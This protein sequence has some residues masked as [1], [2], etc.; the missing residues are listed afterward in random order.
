[1]LYSF[2]SFFVVGIGMGF[3]AL[4]TLLVVQAGLDPKDLGVATASNQFARTLGGTVGVGICGGL[5]ANRFSQLGATIQES[6]LLERFPASM[7]NGSIEKIGQLFNAEVQ[8]AMPLPLKQLVQAAVTEGVGDVFITVT[9]SAS[10]C[11]LM[12]LL[13]PAGSTQR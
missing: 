3:V 12:C 2:S 11:L 4:A 8:A 7:A 10:L 1:V 13:L 9:I 5:V 6:G